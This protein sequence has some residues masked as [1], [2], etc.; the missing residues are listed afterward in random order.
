[1]RKILFVVLIAI[2][3]LATWFFLTKQES[4]PSPVIAAPELNQPVSTALQTNATVRPVVIPSS[5]ASVATNMTRVPIFNLLNEQNL[6]E[7]KAAVPKLGFQM[8]GVWG[9]SQDHTNPGLPFI[10]G[11]VPFNSDSI[12]IYTR[13]DNS[14]NIRRIEM[15]SPIMNITDTRALGDALLQM[16]GKDTADFHA[17]CDK[18][19]NNWLYTPLFDSVGAHLPNGKGCGFSILCGFNG[20]KPWIINFVITDP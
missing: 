5:I 7:W 16:M 18:A 13:G 6:D 14:G 2:V 3:M 4:K 15:Q 17:W 9:M 8:K 10:I 11:S 20:E 12:D 1:M 19:G